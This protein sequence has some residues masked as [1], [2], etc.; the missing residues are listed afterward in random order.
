MWYRIADLTVEMNPVGDMPQRMREYE[1]PE[2]QADIRLVEEDYRLNSWLRRKLD[3]NQAYYMET[4]RVFSDK[5]LW[6]D[7]LMLHSSAVVVGEYA[8]LFSGP[9]GMGKSTHTQG[10]LRTFGRDAVIINDDKPTL[11]RQG[12]TWYAYGTPWCGKDGI[13]RNLS[14]PVAG[15]C[16]LHRGDTLLQRLSP[17]EAAID[18][19]RQT[20]YYQRDK[21]NTQKLLS[22]IDLLAKEVPAFSFHNHAQP[23][24]ASLTYA[25]MSQ[26]IKENTP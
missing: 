21:K 17:A 15:I 26:A 4:G 23:E 25:A 10:Y 11:R 3:I 14:A 13:N 2:G 12:Q 18:I 5:A 6:F 7:S 1:I 19:I 8:Y 9:S 24:D 16:F 20:Q 22:L